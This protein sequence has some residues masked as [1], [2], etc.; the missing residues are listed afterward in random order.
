MTARDNAKPLRP[1]RPKPVAESVSQSYPLADRLRAAIRH[2]WRHPKE[3]L[4]IILTA[5]LAICAVTH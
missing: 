3:A 5:A 4:L 2:H 1:Q